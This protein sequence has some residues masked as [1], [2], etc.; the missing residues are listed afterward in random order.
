MS[1]V[2]VATFISLHL[3]K[4]DTLWYCTQGVCVNR[5]SYGAA[6]VLF[7]VS[8]SSIVVQLSEIVLEKMFL[9]PISF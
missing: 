2:C 3:V 7:L 9:Y 8:S 4:S 6:T 1:P 5:H